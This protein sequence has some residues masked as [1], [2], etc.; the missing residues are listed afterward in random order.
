MFSDI[1]SCKQQRKLRKLAIAIVTLGLIFF[2]APYSRS[3]EKSRENG[4]SLPASPDTGSPEEDFSAGGTR[5]SNQLNK[6][7][8]ENSQ[9]MVYLLGN[10]NRE[11]TLSAH[12][13]FWF[14]L[15]DRVK[16]VAQINF[17]LTELETGKEIYARAL[18]PPEKAGIFGISMPSKPEYTLSPQVNYRWSLEVDCA[19]SDEEPIIALEGWLSRLPLNSDLKNK[20]AA[21]PDE[22]KHL[23][24]LQHNLLYDAL[25]DLVQLRIVQ[26]Q[27][28]EL[29]TAWNQLLVELG[30]QN[31]AQQL[32]VKPF[33]L[34]KKILVNNIQY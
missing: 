17:V 31:L 25:N 1:N 10:R 34:N 8:G 23:V 19:E 9:E 20:L 12:P 27:N 32:A 4:N 30:W 15:P 29:I 7:C 28:T 3:I 6:I 11:F 18:Q 33:L 26:P 2:S 24:Y 16:K 5:D 22:Q 13:T 21:T 14:Y